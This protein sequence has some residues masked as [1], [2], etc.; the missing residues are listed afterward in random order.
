[1]ID[2]SLADLFK[3]PGAFVTNPGKFV[4]FVLYAPKVRGIHAHGDY[5]HSFSRPYND[6][7]L[8]SVLLQ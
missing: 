1:M 7:R 8:T 5:K 4:Q 2:S 3:R 6:R